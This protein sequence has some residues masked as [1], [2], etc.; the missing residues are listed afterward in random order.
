MADN[1]TSGAIMEDKTCP[2]FVDGKECDLLLTGVDAKR[3]DREIRLSDLSMW[4]G[5]SLLFSARA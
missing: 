5:T 2:L 4:P 3:K 1:R